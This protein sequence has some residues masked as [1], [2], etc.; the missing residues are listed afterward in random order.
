MLL[1]WCA[2]GWNGDWGGWRLASPACHFCP[3]CPFPPGKSSKNWAA[4][5]LCLD[6]SLTTDGGYLLLPLEDL[7]LL[8][9][10]RTEEERY[11]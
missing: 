7:V 10:S 11:T 8:M 2:G 6:L 4:S 1:G 3:V 5:S 9:L